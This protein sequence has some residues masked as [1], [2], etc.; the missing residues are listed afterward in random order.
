MAQARGSGRAEEKALTPWRGA[1]G[2]AVVQ[3]AGRRQQMLCSCR[4]GAGA[5]LVQ[6]SQLQVM[7]EI[8]GRKSWW[9]VRSS[10]C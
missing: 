2:V 8:H 10:G 6:G 9:W 4:V 1:V 5:V 7:S 3:G